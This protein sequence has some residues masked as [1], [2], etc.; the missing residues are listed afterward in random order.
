MLP[1]ALQVEALRTEEFRQIFGPH[2]DRTGL[3]LRKPAGDFA[4]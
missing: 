1:S 2:R 3:A 4:S